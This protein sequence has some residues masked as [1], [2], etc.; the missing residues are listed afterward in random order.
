MTASRCSSWRRSDGGLRLVEPG[1]APGTEPGFQFLVVT[2]EFRI[3]V[4]CERNVRRVF[5]IGRRAEAA[6]FEPCAD[7]DRGFVEK[8]KRGDQCVKRFEHCILGCPGCTDDPILVLE[9]LDEKK[10]GA[11]KWRSAAGLSRARRSPR[12]RASARKAMFA[13]TMT[14]VI[15]QCRAG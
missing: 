15:S 3:K 12:L 10:T 5:R 4:Q 1:E 9:Q 7:G 6:G 14:R 11:M 13:S 8:F 2:P